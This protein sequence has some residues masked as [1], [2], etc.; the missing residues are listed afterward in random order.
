[1]G[2]SFDQLCVTVIT[3][4]FDAGADVPKLASDFTI[5][6]TWFMSEKTLGAFQTGRIV[7]E[8]AIF[9]YDSHCYYQVRN[10][11]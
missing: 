3:M 10:T 9:Q 5:T 11:L 4:L 1:M 6:G 8:I 7:I 2:N